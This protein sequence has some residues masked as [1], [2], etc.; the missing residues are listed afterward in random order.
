MTP[1]SNLAQ[2][3]DHDTVLIAGYDAAMPQERRE[4]FED[5]GLLPATPVTRERGAPLGDPIAF[6]VR[7]TRLCLRRAEARLITVRP[8]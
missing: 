3:D 6:K 7:G 8:R 5:L 2:L 4:R 1:P